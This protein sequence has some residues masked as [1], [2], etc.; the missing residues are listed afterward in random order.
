MLTMRPW[1]AL[2]AGVRGFGNQKRTAGVG[3]EHSVPLGGGNVFQG[4]GFERAGVVDEQV[5]AAELSAGGGDRGLNADFISDVHGQ[6]DAVRAGGTQ[7]CECLL[8]V[9]RGILVG[10]SNAGSG[11]SERERDFPTDSPGGSGDERGFCR[12]A[13]PEPEPGSQLRRNPGWVCAGLLVLRVA[14]RLVA[15]DRCNGVRVT[16][17]VCRLRLLDNGIGG[18]GGSAPAR[19]PYGWRL[20]RGDPRRPRSE[21]AGA[22]S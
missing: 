2:R 8:G 11:A 20:H 22:P 19:R 7:I 12:R 14:G 10:D 21:P 16:G 9:T 5:Q 4:H 18:G 3:R 17:V 15:V 1:A 13:G 6:G